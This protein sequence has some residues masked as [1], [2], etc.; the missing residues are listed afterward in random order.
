[1]VDFPSGVPDT[2]P[3]FLAGGNSATSQPSQ[4][5]CTT[6]GLAMLA[7]ANAAAQ[8]VLLGLGTP[9]AVGVQLLAF[10]TLTAGAIFYGSSANTAARLSPGANGTILTVSGG[11]PAWVSLATAGAVGGTG[12][13]GQVSYWSGT[14]TQA[15][16]TGMVYDATNDQ[17]ALSAGTASLPAY[18]IIGDLNTGIY[19]VGAD[20]LGIATGGTLRLDIST[21]AIT[22]TLQ[23]L[24]TNG[25]AAAPQM[26]YSG[27]PNTG[28]YN[29]GADDWGVSTG[30]TLRFDV[31]TTAITST[32]QLLGP[33]GSASAP[34]LSFS[35]DPNTGIYN[36]GADDIGISTGGTVRF[37]I[38]TTAVTSTLPYLNQNG[39]QGAPAFSFSGDP[40]TGM[41]NGGANILSFTTLGT[42]RLTLGSA[43][44]VSVV[45]IAVPVGSAAA[46]SYSFNG[47]T[48]TGIYRSSASTIG[49][50]AAGT[51]RLTIAST[52]T[53]TDATNIAIGT[54]TGSKIG[55]ATS[56]KI[57]FWNVTPVIQPADANQAAITDSTTGTA[58]FTLV[59]VGV[60]FSQTN[61]NNNFASLNRQVD[62]FR[63]ALVASGIIKGAA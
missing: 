21:T 33:V 19:A 32:L 18:S 41:F 14:A 17:L 47:D 58:G 62:A 6:A 9:G 45:N 59:D 26:S 15:G 30:G 8:N 12:V 27:D 29:V 25:S 10:A 20:D 31:S 16:D 63:T 51:L 38:S 11:L 43:S 34:T 7:A 40:D 35:G 50:S 49:F 55:T 4:A 57:G 37:D 56:Q 44:L 60:A 2:T 5:A 42:T 23:F 22:A 39:T 53:V 28:T 1:M 46:P 54:T 36:V 13:A 48:T 3:T 61:V 24:G 52:I